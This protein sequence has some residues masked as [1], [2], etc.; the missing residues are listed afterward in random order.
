MKRLIINADDFGLSPGVNRGILEAFQKGVLTSTTMLVNLDHFAESVAIAKAHPELPVGIHLSLLWGR[1]VSPPESVPTLVSEDGTFPSDLT[2][3]ARRYYTGWLSLA[4]VRAEFAAQVRKLLAAGITPTHADSHKHIHCL[5]GIMRQIASVARE[6]GIERVRYP[7]ERKLRS[8][9]NGATQNGALAPHVS[10]RGRS[11]SALIRFLARN[12]RSILAAAGLRTTDHFVG[13]AQ[14]GAGDPDAL[15]FVFEHLEEGVTELMC[16]AGYT[17]EAANRYSRRP[18]QRD[19]ELAALL[20][21][22]TREALRRCDVTLISYR[23]L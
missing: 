16:H 20:D 10:W 6:Q 11:K 5:P 14:A 3:L 1:P 9:M 19:R 22:R 4:E 23:D 8:R 17:D 2:V 21:A 18:P 7:S 15:R 13:I 12:H